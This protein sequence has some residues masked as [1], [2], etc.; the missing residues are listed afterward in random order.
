MDFIYVALGGALGALGR[1]AIS[2]LSIKTQ[3]PVLTLITNLIGALLIGFVVGFIGEKDDTSKKILLFL[4]T[5]VCGGFTTFST[6]SLETV[7][8]LEKKEYFLGGCYIVFSVL[9]CVVG[10]YAG[11]KIAMYSRR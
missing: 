5:G 8:L 11:N 3:F 6:F 7:N 9:G 4:K 1:F 10:V 2:Q